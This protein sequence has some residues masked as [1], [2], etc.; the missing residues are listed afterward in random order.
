M[1]GA[2]SLARTLV[3]CGV[4]TCFANPGTSEMH[5]VA[6]LDRVPGITSML[7]LFEGVV[8]GAADG[9]ARMADKP[10]A[11]LLHCGPGLAN[12][13]A[14][15]HN[16]RRAWAPVV[17][18]VGDQT[19]SHNPLN[20]LLATDTEG[21]ART[22]SAWVR[23]SGDAR[24]LGA[25][26]AEAVAAARTPPGAVATLIVPSDIAWGEG[27]AVAAP[28]APASPRRA[29]EAAV[30][31]AA[32]ALRS[33]AP[34]MIAMA[35]ANLRAEPVALANRIAAATGATVTAETFNARFTRGR[36]RFPIQRTPY[37]I[38]DAL[39]H[40]ARSRHVIVVGAQDPI[41]FFEYPGRPGRLRPESAELIVLAKPE[42][43]GID[44]LT[45]LADRI[46][47]PEIAPPSPPARPMPATGAITSQAVAR[48]VTALLP[49]DAIVVDEALTFGWAFYAGTEH[50]APHDW[51]QVTGGAIGDGLPL[52]T[53][54]A[55]GAPGRRVVGL[56]ADGSALYTIQA[57][58]TQARQR[59][60]VTTVILSNRR[61][62]ILF[63]ELAGVG[64][65]PGPASERLFSLGDPDLD[66]VKLA[67]GFGV[68]AARADTMERFAELFAHANARPG[69]FLIE[70]VVP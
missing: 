38:D 66:W 57:L 13:L 34:T 8:T 44:A 1:N 69:P 24:Q 48:T 35:G 63:G 7:G 49:E 55:V 27:G 32:R 18:I 65:A 28:L 70:L 11:T 25:D 39:A 64:A 51:M 36:G 17:N 52:A 9:Y 53:G 42:E 37:P 4:D 26:I 6:A 15:L 40:F 33:G 47:A 21:L 30:D 2:E 50:A 20:P 3:A 12:G 5:F 14:N 16:A 56:Q 61:Y 31:A 67:G 45:R 43:D 58:W 59:L 54:A 68:E 29:D 10:A 60:D 46:G 22:E 19:T 62:E 23:T 41:G